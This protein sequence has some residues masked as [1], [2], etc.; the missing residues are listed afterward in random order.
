MVCMCA[1]SHPI[2]WDSMDYSPPGSSVQGI[3]QGRKLPF[4]SPGD[5]PDPGS[6]LS[7]WVLCNGG[8]IL[9]QCATWKPRG[10][11]ERDN[12]GDWDWHIYTENEKT[13]KVKSLSHVWLFATPWTV[14]HQAPP[15]LGFSRQEYWVAI[16]FSRGSSRPRDRTRVSLIVGICFTNLATREV[17]YTYYM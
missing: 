16:S 8:W 2:L 12:L 1:Q 3:F 14:A 17:I 9:Y 4:P 13:V 15:S 5:L 10:E 6:N 7:I 11:M